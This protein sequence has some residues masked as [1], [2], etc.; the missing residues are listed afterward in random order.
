[1]IYSVPMSNLS[2]YTRS[3]YQASQAFSGDCVVLLR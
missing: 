2:P 3:L 1:M